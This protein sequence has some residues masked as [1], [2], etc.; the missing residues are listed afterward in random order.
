M[1]SQV[2]RKEFEDHFNAALEKNWRVQ[3]YSF[4]ENGC[5]MT[6][7]QILVKKSIL[8]LTVELNKTNNI[9]PYKGGE[10]SSVVPFL[11]GLFS[12]R[13]KNQIAPGTVSSF[14]IMNKWQPKNWEHKEIDIEFLGENTT[15]V[16]FT[17][18]HFKE[19][20]K[21]HVYYAYTYKLGFNSSDYYHDYSILWNKNSISWFVD[22]KQV[23]IEKRILFEE[24]MYIRLNH[25]AAAPFN[26]NLMLNWMGPIDT[27]KLP[28][29]VYYDYVKYVPL[30]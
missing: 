16:Q 12:V 30:K 24:A 21:K 3:R 19:G 8:T 10:I 28:S 23:Y 14:F 29:R 7:S 18:H 6:D 9:K 26:N 25:W 22:G 4:P 11:Y 27:S 1:K 15:E 5:E 2:Q 20:G 13:M 17:V